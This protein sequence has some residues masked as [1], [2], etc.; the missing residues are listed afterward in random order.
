MAFRKY[1]M[2]PAPPAT[3]ECPLCAMAIPIQAKKCGHCTSQ[4]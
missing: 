4:L 2:K 1:L 3:K